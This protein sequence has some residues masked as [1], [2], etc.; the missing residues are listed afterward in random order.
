MCPIYSIVTF[1][2]HFC[3]IVPRQ[4]MLY[5]GL[6]SINIRRNYL[7][8]T[9]QQG[10]DQS[11]WINGNETLDTMCNLY[12]AKFCLQCPCNMSPAMHF[13]KLSKAFWTRKTKNILPET[14]SLIN[15]KHCNIKDY[16]RLVCMKNHH[17]NTIIENWFEKCLSGVKHLSSLRNGSQVLCQTK[18]MRSR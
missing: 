8:V 11:Q 14:G 2:F 18:Y 13:S 1:L 17:Q 12:L 5:L 3:R 9:P 6:I 10:K 16:I 15:W 7:V 4:C